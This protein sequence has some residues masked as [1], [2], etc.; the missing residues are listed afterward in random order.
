VEPPNLHRQRGYQHRE[1]EEQRH[2]NGDIARHAATRPAQPAHEDGEDE[3]DEHDE[4]HEHPIFP[5]RGAAREIRIAEQRQKHGFH[6][7][8]PRNPR[9]N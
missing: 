6:E 7:I 8:P 4:Q 1:P 3:N 9:G 2:Q 5:P